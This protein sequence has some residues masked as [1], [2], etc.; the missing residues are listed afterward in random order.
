MASK[1]WMARTAAWGAALLISTSAFAADLGGRPYRGSIKDEP[2]YAPAFSW[3][4]LYVGANVGYGWGEGFNDPEGWFGGGQVGYNVQTGSLVFGLEIDYQGAGID[5]SG[6]NSSPAAAFIG[7]AS[8]E[9]SS[10]GT[11]RGRIGMAFDRVLV[12]ATGGFAFA[13]VDTSLAAIQTGT[14]NRLGF[15]E[16]DTR[17]GYVLGAGVEWAFAPKWSFKL[18][19]QYL[20]FDKDSVTVQSFTAGGLPTGQF[21]EVDRDLDLHTIRAG[22]NY[23]F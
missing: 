18:E 8:S 22:V 23:R 11:V 10:F 5:A 15:S 21:F 12:Y 2:V 7:S 17:T 3:T 16:S 20:N 6:G 19:Y 14:G 9:I 4:G 1:K 13:E